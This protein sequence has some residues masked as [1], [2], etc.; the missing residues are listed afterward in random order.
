MSECVQV[1]LHGAAEV[2]L[3][4]AMRDGASD[5]QLSEVISAAVLRKKKQH[6]GV[7]QSSCDLVLTGIVVFRHRK[8]PA[9][10]E[11][12]DDSHWRMTPKS[13][14]QV[15]Q[16]ASSSSSSSMFTPIS[17]VPMRFYSLPSTKHYHQVRY[18][19]SFSPGT[20]LTHKT[21]SIS[22]SF[23]SFELPS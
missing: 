10:A 8:P 20:S 15:P 2:N 23:L 12:T 22:G 17:N 11:S 16:I 14:L 4:R 1:C 5:E 13:F 19:S 9:S 6:A 21:I 7:A 18:F 3:L